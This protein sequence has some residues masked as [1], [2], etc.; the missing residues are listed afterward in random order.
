MFD[1]AQILRRN[2]FL[3]FAQDARREVLQSP[4]LCLPG[5]ADRP[6]EGLLIRC[7]CHSLC[8]ADTRNSVPRAKIASRNPWFLKL[9]NRRLDPKGLPIFVRGH[10]PPLMKKGGGARSPVAERKLSERSGED[11]VVAFAVAWNFPPVTPSD[12]P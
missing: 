2:R 11:R 10:V 5:F 3:V 8:Y 1:I 12:C 4:P 9:A 7:H 6:A